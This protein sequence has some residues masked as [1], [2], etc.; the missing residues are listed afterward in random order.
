MTTA[1][2]GGNPFAF[3][4][5]DV[6]DAFPAP[7]AA[8][9]P[10]FV[11]VVAPSFR[12]DADGDAGGFGEDATPRARSDLRSRRGG[13]GCKAS[14]SL[15]V[16]AVLELEKVKTI[17]ALVESPWRARF[18]TAL[19]KVIYGCTAA[20]SDQ[21][22]SASECAHMCVSTCISLNG[23][24]N[25]RLAFDSSYLLISPEATTAADPPPL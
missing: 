14:P 22:V 17:F 18:S 21:S 19:Q 3:A 6:P 10:S 4:D 25:G 13:I 9:I 24:Q 15:G 16:G 8:L 7:D 2:V 5:D 1:G 12:C 20:N 11:D 23:R